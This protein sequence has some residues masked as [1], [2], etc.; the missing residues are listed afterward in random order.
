M[1]DQTESTVM[2][3]GPCDECGSSDAR[4]VY[5]DGHTYCYACPEETAYGKPESTSTENPQKTEKPS[6]SL[7]PVGE[8]SA[9]GKR[10]LTEETCKKFSYSI[11]TDPRTNKPCQI[12]NFKKDGKIVAQKIRYANKDFKF[13]G[14]TKVGLWGAHLW[15]DGGRMLVITEGEIDCMTVSQLQGNKWPVVSLPNGAQNARKAVQQSLEFVSSYD[16]VVIMFDMDEPGREAA[17]E[18]AKLLKPGQAFIASLPFKDPNECLIKGE[19]KSVVSAMWDAKPYRPDGI[20]N[21]SD[22]WERV[23]KPKENNM[24]EYPWEALQAKTRGARKGELVV[25]TAG[26]GVGKSAVIR[27]IA[28]DFMN[29]GQTVGMIM[30]EEGI[31]R[32]ALGMMGLHLNHP[33]HLDRGDFTQEQLHEAFQATA[34]SGRLWLYDHFGS[35]SAGNLLERVRYLAVGCGCDFI[36]L[37]HLSIAVSDAEANTDTNLDERKL[38][39]MLMTKLRSLVEELGIGLFVISHLKRP[40]MGKGHEEGAQTSL[41]QLR[42]S[43]AIAQLSDFVIGLERNQQDDE[44]SNTTT[45]RVLKNRFSGETGEA[46]SLFYD[47]GTGRLHDHR[48]IP[49]SDIPKAGSPSGDY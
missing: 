23:S 6:L 30:L 10:R 25:L 41:S 24:V 9:L 49:V 12:A 4:A 11:S 36:V 45:L 15:R 38:I 42:G 34:G 14:D 21:A 7:F 37:D 31:D 43:H 19:G 17:V 8:F 39:D 27:E 1:D 2:F 28:H 5:D 47:Q 3:K 46:G 48:M 20:V 40:G 16:K 44:D 29:K 35:T 26:S 33:L 22:L 32:T 18:V 13:L